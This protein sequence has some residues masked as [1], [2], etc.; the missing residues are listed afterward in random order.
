MSRWSRGSMSV[1]CP[2]CTARLLKIYQFPLR[3]WLVL[4]AA[5]LRLANAFGAKPYRGVRRLEVENCSGVI[6]VRASGSIE[7]ELLAP[8]LSVARH[9]VEF[10]VIIPFTSLRLTLGLWRLD[11]C[12]KRH[13]DGALA[14]NTLKSATQCTQA[15]VVI[16]ITSLTPDSRFETR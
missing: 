15:K 13:S 16:C 7:T 11:S 6:V 4:L 2:I 12:S 1:L 3:Q 10:A 9:L 8:K 5:M 14:I